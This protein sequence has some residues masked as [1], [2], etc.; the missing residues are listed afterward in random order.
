MAWQ[1]GVVLDA[2]RR[3]EL[4]ARSPGVLRL[5]HGQMNGLDMARQVEQA[6]RVNLPRS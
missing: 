2:M 5:T 6:G 3:A 4:L 1:R